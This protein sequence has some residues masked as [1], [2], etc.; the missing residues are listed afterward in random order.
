MGIWRRYVAEDKDFLALGDINLCAK[1]WDEP[2]YTHSQLADLVKDF[3]ME[4]NCCQVVDGYTRLRMV[5]G[6]MQRSCLD[7]VIVNCVDKISNVEIHGVGKSDHMGILLNK[8]S[9]EVRTC[10]KTTRKR[11]YKNFNCDSFVED[12]RAAKEMGK[13]NP[14]LENDDIEAAGDTFTKVF[15]EI[16]DKHAP[17]KVIQNRKNYQPYLSNEIKEIMSKRDNLK[18]DAAVTGNANTYREYQNLRNEITKLLKNAESN[19]YGNKYSDPDCSPQDV[20]KMT[21]QILGKSRSDFPAQMMF[22]TKL[23]SKPIQIANAMNDFFLK[24]ISTLKESFF[25]DDD[26]KVELRRFLSEKNIPGFSLRE[27]TESETRKLIKKMK[28]K[29]SC[30]LDWICGFSLKLAAP[31]LIPEITALVNISI[32]S[33]KFYTKWK[34]AKVLP[35]YKCK[36]SKFDCKFYRPI[37]NLAEMS[38]FQERIVHNQLYEYLC[39]NHLLHP[40]HHGFL[41]HHSTATALHQIIDTW[42]Q[43]ADS[44]KLSATLLLD[45]KA[46]F[47]VIE[48]SVLLGKLK[49]YGLSD[50]TTAWF[51]SYLTDRTQCVQIESALSDLKPV[52]WGVPQGSILGPLLFIIYINELPEVVNNPENHETKSDI[53]IYADD[54]SPTTANSDPGEL[55]TRIQSDGN[56]VTNWFSKNKMVCSGEKTKLLVSGTRA[57]RQLKLNTIQQVEVCGDIINES[58]SEKLLGVVVNNTITWKNHLYGN[59]EEE[60][61][62][63]NLSK[64]VGMLKRLRKHLPDSKFKQTVSA[65][66]SSKLYYCITVW[67]GVWNIPGDLSETVGRNMSITKDEM[68]KLQVMHNKCMRMMTGLDRYSSTA[69][70]LKKSNMLSAHQTVAHQ[71]AVQLFNVLKNRAPAY[72]YQRLFPQLHHDTGQIENMEVRSVTNLNS[73]V[74]FSGAL[75]QSS[76]FYQSSRIWCTLPMSMKTADTVQ[77]FKNRCKSWVKMNITIKP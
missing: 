35:G 45:L 60:G 75:G 32:R 30:G 10:T 40:S 20:W 65:L 57:N 73:R 3:M 34:Q 52:I 71:S 1:Q 4:E 22:G 54:N 29:R 24:K 13:F 9:R 63:K 41:Q 76:Y 44:G 59:D 50:L 55:L 7:H 42:L 46:G 49:E 43:A 28:G 8:F 70:L 74:D 38:K 77:T 53:I 64:R 37:S 26:P 61:L 17:L 15:S 2:G 18:E 66:F 72:H 14:I 68:R 19:H 48:H 11:V 31:E 67:G 5:N 6:S 23:I 39:T 16:L 12:I 21:S 56:K 51:E 36:G 69:D 62:L 58:T 27:I 47:D 25:Q 33:G